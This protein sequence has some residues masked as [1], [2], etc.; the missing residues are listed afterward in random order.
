MEDPNFHHWYRLKENAANAFVDAV[1]YLN[2]VLT[3]S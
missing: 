3:L 2:Y 1:N